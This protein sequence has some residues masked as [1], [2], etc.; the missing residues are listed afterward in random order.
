MSRVTMFL[1][2]LLVLA[3]A[4]V[5]SG[6][7][8]TGDSTP[9]EGSGQSQAG[10]ADEHEGHEHG[11]D[12]GHDQGEAEKEKTLA[13]LSPEDRQLVE[14]QR[15]CPVSEGLLWEMGKPYKTTVKTSDATERVVF[16]CCQGCE[17]ELRNEPDKYLAKLNK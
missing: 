16:L 13:D 8:R 5:F 9:S 2:G 14:Q 1:S 11:D 7:S 10:A 12:A 15:I 17:E 6:C 3:I 4:V